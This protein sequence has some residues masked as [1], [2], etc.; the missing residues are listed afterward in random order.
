MAILPPIPLYRRILRA[1]RKH[2]PVKMR[3]LGDEYV[4]AEFHA[5]KDIDNP[6]HLVR[7]SIF[8]LLNLARQR[9]ERERGGETEI[10][11]GDLTLG[12]GTK[13]LKD[14]VPNG[15]ATLRPEGRGRRL[16]RGQAGSDK[17]CEDERY[18]I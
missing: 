11:M 13:Q 3:L 2:L 15:V 4:K 12:I 1:H 18:V 9:R 17:G 8:L 6:A 14:R 16:G 10:E 5:H 7:R